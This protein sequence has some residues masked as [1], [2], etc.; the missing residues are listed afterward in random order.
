[1]RLTGIEQ[2]TKLKNIEKKGFAEL[3]ISS[4]Y[5]VHTEKYLIRMSSPLPKALAEWGFTSDSRAS[6]DT[7]EWN[8]RY[9]NT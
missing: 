3:L 6:Q 9:R 1:M 5:K 2:I 8:K 4:P 7:Q